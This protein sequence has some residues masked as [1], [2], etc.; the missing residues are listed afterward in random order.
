[1]YIIEALEVVCGIGEF[2]DDLEVT[3]LEELSPRVD[4]QRGVGVFYG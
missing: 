2:G 4:G 1:M 3:E